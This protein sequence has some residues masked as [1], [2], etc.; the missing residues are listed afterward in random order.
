MT[1]ESR[2]VAPV[3]AIR[4]ARNDRDVETAAD[5]VDEY[6]AWLVSSGMLA[7]REPNELRDAEAAASFREPRGCLLLA[8]C[9]GVAVGCV[10]LKPLADSAACEVKRLYVRPSFRA[11][12]AGRKLV[13]AL[14]TRARAAG[15]HD[16]RLDTLPG[17][18]AAIRMY[19]QLGFRPRGP[20]HDSHPP[21]ALYF[22]LKL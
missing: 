15:Y 9:D 20:Y 2:P 7:E 22:E 3:V 4:A 1:S 8:E 17:M 16:M 5:L 12:G 14:V 13:E 19:E 10:G 18:A 6:E 21:G 11:I